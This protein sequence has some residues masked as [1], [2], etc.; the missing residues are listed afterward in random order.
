MRS[1]QF[2]TLSKNRGGLDADY[3]AVL[4]RADV[5]G[6]TKPSTAQ[7][8]L[9]SNIVKALKSAN[10]W[11][12]LDC[13]YCFA[14][15]GSQQFAYLNWKAPSSNE[16]SVV[17]SIGYDANVG[18]KG[19][20]AGYLDTNFA[21]GTHAIQGSQDSASIFLN[22]ESNSGTQYLVSSTDRRPSWRGGSGQAEYRMNAQ[23]NAGTA[24]NINQTGLN[25]MTRNSSSNIKYRDSVNNDEAISQTSASAAFNAELIL[26]ALNSSNFA[27]SGVQ[28]SFFGY[29]GDIHS[30][31]A[32]LN[33]ALSDYM[34]AI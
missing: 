30:S 24:L 13:F 17:T 22:L 6:Y 2:V 8:A 7:Q 20:G 31:Y 9:Q 4:D 18:F 3:Q 33:T 12:S 23:S 15:D 11:D 27:S 32:D 29:G 10:I 19:D 16:I 21:P 5:Q 14:N 34:S 1:N 25:L 28:I 26:L